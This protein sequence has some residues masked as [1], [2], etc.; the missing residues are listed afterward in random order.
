MKQHDITVGTVRSPCLAAG[1]GSEAAVFVHGNPGSGEDWRALVSGAGEFMRAVAPHMP[2]FGKADKPAD[3]DYTVDGYARHLGGVIDALGIDRVHL[4]VHDF[5]GPWGLRWAAQHPSRLA[6]I[7]L[8]NIGILRGYRWHFMA[9]IWRTPL[10]GELSQLATTRAG[11]RLLLKVGNPRGLPLAFIDRMYDDFDAGTKRA[12]L[13]LYRATTDLDTY[14][15]DLHA[16]LRPLDLP[17]LVIWGLADIYLP[18]RFARAQLDTF[19]RARVVELP[20]SGHFPYADNPQA[21]AGALLPFL[22]ERRG[23]APAEP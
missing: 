14:A 13:K 7:T 17:A 4:V 18:G 1:G 15:N 16:A 10:L 3:F 19:P 6:S 11:F 5:G 20:D 22:R 9:R 21:V 12:I 2:G 8:V 23:K